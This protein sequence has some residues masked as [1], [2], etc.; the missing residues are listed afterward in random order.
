MKIVWTPHAQADLRAV[1]DYIAADSPAN[2][3][4]MISRLISRV[5]QLN[6]F[7]RSGRKVPELD[8]DDICELIEAPY[9]VIYRIAE[10]RIEIASVVHGGRMLRLPS[11]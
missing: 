4:R 7:T 1:R 6:T 2:A 3:T 9:R 10:D 8:Q 11:D 5:R